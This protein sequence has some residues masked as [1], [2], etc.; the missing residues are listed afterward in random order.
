MEWDVKWKKLERKK[1][2][3]HKMVAAKAEEG[4]VHLCELDC[5]HK[6]TKESKIKEA[7][8]NK[9]RPKCFVYVC[10]CTVKISGI[11][12][13]LTLSLSL[14]RPHYSLTHSLSLSVCAS[15]C[16]CI[17]TARSNGELW[18]WRVAYQSNCFVRF[19]TDE[20]RKQSLCIVF[21]IHLMFHLFILLQQRIQ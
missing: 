15:L 16:V 3:T 19:A 2:R 4:W 17:F 12:A 21:L 1:E 10:L 18:R 13:R 14:S 6:W 7:K 8:A 9:E 11:S 20:V 5:G